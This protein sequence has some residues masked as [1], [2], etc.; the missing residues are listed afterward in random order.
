MFTRDTLCKLFHGSRS[1]LAL[2][3]NPTLQDVALGRV[4]K[5]RVEG[6]NGDEGVP[7]QNGTYVGDRQLT[8]GAFLGIACVSG[9][10]Q[11]VCNSGI[12]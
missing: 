5:E 2:I 6:S 1:L 9:G 12:H 7:F 11:T 10:Y 8:N 3:S 4:E